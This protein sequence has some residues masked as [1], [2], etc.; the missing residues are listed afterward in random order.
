M[1]L[2]CFRV[3]DLSLS[4]IVQSDQAVL[5]ACQDQ[6]IFVGEVAIQARRCLVISED[7]CLRLFALNIEHSDLMVSAAGYKH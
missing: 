5:V 6:L 1:A 3:L 4:Q 7:R 2:E